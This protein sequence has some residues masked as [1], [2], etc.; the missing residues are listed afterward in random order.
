M[1]SSADCFKNAYLFLIHILNVLYV[2]GTVYQIKKNSYAVR[3]CYAS[4]HA[5]REVYQGELCMS[6]FTRL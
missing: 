3:D 4:V 6:G 2:K 1:K 5:A